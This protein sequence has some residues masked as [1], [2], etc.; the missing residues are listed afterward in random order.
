MKTSHTRSRSKSQKNGFAFR[1]Q[2]LSPTQVLYTANHLTKHFPTFIFHIPH[3]Y[4]FLSE[5][6]VHLSMH[7]YTEKARWSLALLSVLC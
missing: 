3:A 5:A 4:L 6:T 1:L 7:L 2:S